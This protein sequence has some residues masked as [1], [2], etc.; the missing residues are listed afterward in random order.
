[1]M[2]GLSSTA[3]NAL[4]GVIIDIGSG[5]VGIGIIHSDQREDLP[6]VL[7][8]HRVYM[9]VSKSGGAEDERFREMR[10]ALFSASLILSKEGILALREYDARGKIG[11]ILVTCSSPWAHTV[12]KNVT[13]EQDKPFKVSKSIIKD[14]ITTA[15]SQIAESIEESALVGSMG[16]KVVEKATVNVR[17]NGYPIHEPIGLSGT[18]VELS[19]ITGLLPAEV[20]DAVY[21]VQE[22]IL[23]DTEI[24]A[25]T[26]MLVIYCVLRDLFPRTESLCIVDV[27]GE[28][29]EIGVV[30]NGI[31]T[32]TVHAP[33]GSNTLLRH[34]AEKADVTPRE[35]V[36]LLRG[37]TD[38]TLSE[39]K[40]GEVQKLL[41]GYSASVGVV[42]DELHR[43]KTI[44]TTL[45]ITGTPELEALFASL[46]P[47][48]ATDSTK[49]SFKIIK[50]KKGTLDEIAV[51]ENEDIFISIAA[52]FFHKLHGC[53]EIDGK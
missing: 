35:A 22:K 40:H 36:A 46:I 44:P 53:G 51:H 25:H 32:E 41:E 49:R 27:T 5:S 11:R 6:K 47:Q 20:L 21:E 52:R 34:I 42:F 3:K 24:S 8:S 50:I 39:T 26:Y 43:G 28:S 12:S 31:L 15:E 45:A 13:Y 19:H 1:M 14:L 10:E 30:Q 7:F 9:R 23:P 17:L 29:T 38:Q 2:F 18:L 16:L 48:I 4:Y 37:Y 33:Y